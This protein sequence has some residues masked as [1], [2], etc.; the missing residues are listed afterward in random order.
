[1]SVSTAVEAAEAVRMGRLSSETLVRA[2]LDR[3]AAREATVQA[4]TYLDPEHALG[5]ARAADRA[6]QEGRDLGP[7]HGMPVGVKDVFDTADMPTEYGTVLHAGRQPV[8]D[9]FTVALLRRAGAV[10]LGK[11]V[12]TELG[13]VAPGKTRNPHDPTRTPGGSSS[14]SAAAVADGMV[15]LAVGSQNNGSVIRPASYCGVYGFKPTAGR[16]SRTG[17][18]VQSPSLD[19][20]GVFAATLADTALLAETLMAFDPRD[21]AMRPVARPAL[22]AALRDG[23]PRRPRIAVVQSPVWEQA[24][25]ACRE[26][27][28]ALAKSLGDA[29]TAVELP[30]EFTQAHAVH[31]T[32][33]E[34]ELAQHYAGEYA[35]GK[36]HLS[37]T[38]CEIIQRGQ[39]GRT[40]DYNRAQAQA[41][42][43]ARSLDAFF[44][45]W[46]A[47]LTPATM[48]A[49]PEGLAST[50]SPIFCTIW[51]LCGAPAISLP[52]LRG[53]AGLPLGAQLVAARGCDAK[54]LQVARWI[55][56]A[57]GR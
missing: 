32:I 30:D 46:D 1:M 13:L 43:L 22:S 40:V 28:G 45:H 51:T 38:L 34:P 6:R 16:L 10:I 5:Q 54:L 8:E 31:K 53:A 37:P 26:A 25:P 36:E 19:Q 24:S 4:W 57:I 7:L 35:R 33:M 12:C 56:A 55:A 52:I 39:Q 48:D 18:L 15:P 14:G 27:L 20:L 17:V 29:A 47:I 49:A 9:A 50:G 3:I 21:P 44:T 41:A 23:F 42:A 11:T 2:C